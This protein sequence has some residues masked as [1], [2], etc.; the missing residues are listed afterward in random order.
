M[1]N[2]AKW[3][4][5]LSTEKGVRMLPGT[6]T[7]V[8]GGDEEQNRALGRCHLAHRSGDRRV[9]RDKLEGMTRCGVGALHPRPQKLS[10]KAVSDSSSFGKT[11]R[12]KG[13]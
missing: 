13:G 6:E 4:L 1:E 7:G 9:C 10:R 12:R 3:P 8:E 2:W 5:Q 11:P